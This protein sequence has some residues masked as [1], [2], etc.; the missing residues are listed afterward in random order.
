MNVILTAYDNGDSSVGIGANQWTLTIPVEDAMDDSYARPTKEILASSERL[1][2]IWVAFKKLY[3]QF[4]D[5]PC[6]VC[7]E[8]PEVGFYTD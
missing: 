8:C 1:T 5:F 6:R 4:N 3:N 7:A 2:D